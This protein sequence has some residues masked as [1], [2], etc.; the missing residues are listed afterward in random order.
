MVVV[1]IVLIVICGVLAYNLYN[2][3]KEN[4]NLKISRLKYIKYLEELGYE[5]TIH[6]STKAMKSHMA[7]KN[8]ILI[9]KLK[10]MAKF[11]ILQILNILK[12][13]LNC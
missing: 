12:I 10:L 5:K 2:I 8:T 1:I 13:K 3:N 4:E 7:F 9:P 11:T 6:T